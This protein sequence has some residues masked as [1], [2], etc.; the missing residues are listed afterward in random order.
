MTVAG[1]V[2]PR[3]L[4]WGSATSTIAVAAEDVATTVSTAGPNVALGSVEACCG[5][6][7]TLGSYSCCGAQE[8][9][10]DD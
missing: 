2:G 5:A 3:P 6:R 10:E 4:R 8:G 7:A 9:Q 1:P